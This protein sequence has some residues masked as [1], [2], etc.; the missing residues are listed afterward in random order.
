MSSRSVATLGV[1]TALVAALGFALT[2]VPNVELMSLSTFVCGALRGPVGGGVVG[3]S[4]MAIYSSFNPYGIAPPPVFAMQLVGLGIIGVVGGLICGRP[5]SRWR[6]G[7][8]SGMLAGGILGFAL[9]LLYDVLTNLGTAWSMGVY[10]N[11]LPIL[12]G[13]LGFGAWH[14][15]W[16][17]VLFAACSPTLLA[18]LRRR[19]ARA[20]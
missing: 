17:T 4:A 7:G 14:M 8:I 13:G 16:N 15:V 20:L 9:T 12:L 3:A 1:L 11:P 2:G 10:R 18:A 5:S 19:E 6:P